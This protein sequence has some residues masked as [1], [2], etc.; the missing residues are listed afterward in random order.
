MVEEE[1][2]R[3][4]TIPLRNVKSSPRNGRADRAVR[5]VRTY[6]SKHMKADEVWIDAAVNQKIWERGKYKIPSRIRV[7]ARLFDDG[8]VEV[9]LPEEESG[10]A[11]MRESL[12]EERE[13][14]LEALHK[15]EEEEEEPADEAS[16]DEDTAKEV[17]GED[18]ETAGEEPKEKA[19]PAPA[20]EPGA[21]ADP[22]EESS[23]EKQ[24]SPAGKKPA[25]GSKDE[26]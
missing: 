1:L 17:S 2:E 5:A 9:S 12:E 21:S 15:P 25:S 3:I 16:E 23:D 6:L 22:P 8:V 4:Y 20:K 7:R 24:A 14:K 13:K 11:S 26:E 19:M 10:K 18:E